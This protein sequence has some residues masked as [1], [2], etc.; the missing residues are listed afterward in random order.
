[1]HNSKP[2]PAVGNRLKKKKQVEAKA[3][4]PTL[5]RFPEAV[6]SL[7]SDKELFRCRRDRVVRWYL[8]SLCLIGEKHAGRES[9][10]DERMRVLAGKLDAYSRGGD[11]QNDQA[12]V[13]TRFYLIADLESQTTVAM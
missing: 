13:P 1:M 2:A 12:L 10:L 9:S 3:R 5:W 4:S 8:L 6:E 11:K 7:E